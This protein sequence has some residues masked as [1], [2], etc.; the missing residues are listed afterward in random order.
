MTRSTRTSDG[1]RE[2]SLGDAART[3]DNSPMDGRRS[4]NRALRAV[5]LCALGA[6]GAPLVGCQAGPGSTQRAPAYPPGPLGS[7]TPSNGGGFRRGVAAGN[8]PVE[9]HRPR[10][11]R[12]RTSGLLF[13][14]GSQNQRLVK[15]D[16]VDGM[17]VFEGD[18]LLGP[19]ATVPFRFGLPR[20]PPRGNAKGAVTLI[21]RSHLWPNSEIPY[22]IDSSVSATQV[23]FINTAISQINQTE[24]KIRP[25]AA[26]D[27][28][29]VSFHDSGSGAGCSSF[30]GR[31]GG[32][33]QIEV[34]DCG[35]GSVTHELLHAGG[36]YHE[37][38]RGDRDDFITIVFDEIAPEFRD[39]FE[40]RDGRG[41][42]IGPYD[43]GSIMH[44]SARAFSRSGRPT[45]I[46]KVPGAQ[47]GQRE[48]PSVGD[49]AAI[50]QLYGG[51]APRPPAPGGGAPPVAPTAPSPSASGSFAGAY[52][53]T[54]GS[55]TCTQIG[56]TVNCQFP[57]GTMLCGASGTQL[58]CGWSGGG[59]GR[60][61]FQRQSSGT[62]AGTF[63]DLFSANSRGAWELVPAGAAPPSQPAGPTTPPSPSSS[64][65]LSGR[66]ASTR[67]PMNC[68][69]GGA[70]MACSFQEAAGGVPG[71]LDCTK[72]AS[73]LQLS[74]GWITFFPPAAGRASFRR[75]SSA[76]RNLTG[77]W[78]QAQSD[79]GAG[80]WQAKPQ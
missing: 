22:V 61:V 79:A 57:G 67:G 26:T 63:G 38:S 30:L 32:P 37:Q 45:I 8:T 25:R 23:G 78:G 65:S 1:T 58:D 35:Q 36:F 75:A 10:S 59:Q 5:A 60:A 42:D 64:A 68:A 4:M 17:A 18:I 44:Y 41:Q 39:E 9:T 71:R 46:P 2:D 15:Y 47:I 29:F 56:S 51:G 20:T 43:Y 14:A 50:A 77:T 28:D 48:G 62:L 24:L 19:A 74:C 52:T 11:A 55:V 7:Q 73:G 3:W 13:L 53:S 49:K 70:T 69:D 34:A 40:K 12:Q 66:Y 54:R 72:D 27:N 21:D 76:D 16:V 31:I 80:N 6:T 33:Q